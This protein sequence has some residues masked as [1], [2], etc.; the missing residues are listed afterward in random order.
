[1][2]DEHVP[3]LQSMGAAILLFA[4]AFWV[5]V[6]IG[7]ARRGYFGPVVRSTGRTPRV[8]RRQR[9]SA[10]TLENVELTPA[11]RDA[12]AGLVRRLSDGS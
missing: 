3:V 5:F 9:R 2:P 8:L 1:M 11:E 7:L 6:L 10:P 12:F 4:A